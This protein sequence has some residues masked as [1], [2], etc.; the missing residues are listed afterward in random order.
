MTRSAVVR[1][2][3]QGSGGQWFESWWELIYTKDYELICLACRSRLIHPTFVGLCFLFY[4]SFSK[5]C[6]VSFVEVF[7]TRI[8]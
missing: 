8:T 7:L 3:G 1:A 2:G 6:I 5:H 4:A